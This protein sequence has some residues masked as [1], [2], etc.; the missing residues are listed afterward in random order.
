MD[1]WDIISA[2]YCRLVVFGNMMLQYDG[3]NVGMRIWKYIVRVLFPTKII[4]TKSWGC[5]LV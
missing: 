4:K 3:L 1:E 2:I 5:R